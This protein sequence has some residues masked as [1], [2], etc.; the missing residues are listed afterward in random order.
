MFYQLWSV[1]NCWYCVHTRV[2]GR[3]VL[4]GIWIWFESTNKWICY[5][6]E[7]LLLYCMLWSHALFL[8]LIVVLKTVR[9][10]IGCLLNMGE[11]QINCKKRNVNDN[12][13][14]NT[15]FQK[16]SGWKS[17]VGNLWKCQIRKGMDNYRMEIAESFLGNSQYFFKYSFVRDY[18]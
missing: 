8:K 5:T 3:V 18:Q 6:N 14:I 12:H 4:K 16:S 11:F 1:T 9:V 7:S 2:S 10:W 15:L 13:Q 17:A